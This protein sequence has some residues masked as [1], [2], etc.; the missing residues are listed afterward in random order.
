MADHAELRTAVLEGKR[1]KAEELTRAALAAGA[2][3]GALL[4]DALISAMTE[5]GEKFSSGE[6]FVPE[7]LVAAKAMKASLELLRPH[8]KAGTIGASGRV[9]LGTV[10]GD[11][12]D[13]GKN[14]V[15]VMLEGA[16]YE[17]VDLGVDAAPERFVEAVRTHK[18]QVVAMSALLT[19]TMLAMPDT[20]K[21]LEAAGVRDAVKVIIGGAAT[22]EAFA[23]EISADGYGVDAAHA[24]SLARRFTGAAT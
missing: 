1:V 21:A 9:V 5:V 6:Y 20:I 10:R 17:V 13:I 19:T 22:T 4:K 11:L 7:M 15:K 2:D 24:V 16:G 8:L 14:L 3:P 23:K 18:P 12:H